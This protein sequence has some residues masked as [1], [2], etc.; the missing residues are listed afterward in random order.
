MC[1]NVNESQKHYIEQKKPDSKKRRL[2]YDYIYVKLT[3]RAMFLFFQLFNLEY[4][5]LTML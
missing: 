3:K 2:M 5:Q 1:N 4:S